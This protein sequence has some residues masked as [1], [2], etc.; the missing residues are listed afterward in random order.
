MMRLRAE[1]TVAAPRP[2]DAVTGLRLIAALMVANAHGVLHF[3]NYTAGGLRPLENQTLVSLLLVKPASIGMSLF[4]VLSGFVIHYN[5]FNRLK[6]FDGRQL[7]NFYTARIARLFPLYFLLVGLEM[8]LGKVMLITIN[9]RSLAHVDAGY[10]IAALPY[11]FT[12]A[13]SWIWK[14]A[15]GLP[16]IFQYGVTS[17]VSWSIST[18]WFFYLTFPVLTLFFR[19]LKILKTTVVCC[20]CYTALAFVF[21]GLVAIN[22]GAID[23]FATARF[24]PVASL[25][26]NEAFSFVL[27]VTYFW[28]VSRLLDFIGGCFVGHIYLL[29]AGQHSSWLSGRAAGYATWGALLIIVATHAVIWFPDSSSA[30]HPLI[31][32]AS[33]F[34][35]APGMMLLIYLV[36][37]HPSPVARLLASR[38]LV[39]G[40]NI[41]YSIYLLH[42]WIW[43]LFQHPAIALRPV[44]YL[45]LILRYLVAI[46]LLLA[47][48]YATY[49]LVE[50][51]SRRA[52]RN[53]LSLGAG[54]CG[55][56]RGVRR[57]VVAAV[58]AAPF[59]VILAGETLNLYGPNRISDL[60]A[61]YGGNCGT[62]YFQ[63]SEKLSEKCVGL[64]SCSFPVGTANLDDAGEVCV[65]DFLVEWWCSQDNRR[66]HVSSL[67]AVAGGSTVELSCA[68]E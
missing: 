10:S 55:R 16:L 25:A 48:A 18:E 49:K 51:P 8:L 53:L 6:N 58:L 31:V 64:A 28:P 7:H 1:A 66:F 33:N 9:G 27:W 40:G 38:S 32:L 37:A 29:S 65:R 30:F 35:Y 24:G 44:P 2:S 60:A 34:G 13:Q 12:L 26:H 23:A 46:G 59:V 56:W 17:Q 21:V 15:N 5:Y 39:L 61:R 4:F 63:F 54:V 50:M 57:T 14:Y 11:H 67:A 43:D 41:S 19:K 3:I 47:A 42:M 36:A 22:V 20:I 52:L 68:V 62:K 45:L